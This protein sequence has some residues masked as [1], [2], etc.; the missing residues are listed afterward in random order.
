MNTALEN[1]AADLQKEKQERGEMSAVYK[2][3]LKE[4]K[5]LLKVSLLRVNHLGHLG[6]YHLHIGIIICINGGFKMEPIQI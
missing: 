1:S 3:K 6:L 4:H 2:N 5:L